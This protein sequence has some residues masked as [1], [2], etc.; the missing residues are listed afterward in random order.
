MWADAA[1]LQARRR[2]IVRDERAPTSACQAVH[3]PIG[4]AAATVFAYATS[5]KTPHKRCTM[6]P[7]NALIGAVA[8]RALPG[9]AYTLVPERSAAYAWLARMSASASCG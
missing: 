7:G 4:A 3:L 5:S 1:E 2:Q 6:T 8:S 9:Y